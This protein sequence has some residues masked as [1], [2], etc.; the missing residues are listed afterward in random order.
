MT[1]VYCGKKLFNYEC[2]DYMDGCLREGPC[3][4]KITEQPPR[5]K[6]TIYVVYPKAW[7]E[8]MINRNN[9]SMKV[10]E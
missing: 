6:R 3:E 8:E 9:K 1:L 2:P 7:K 4:F 5:D 10:K